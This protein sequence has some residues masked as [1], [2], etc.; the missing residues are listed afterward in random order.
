MI[1]NTDTDYKSLVLNGTKNKANL[2]FT[3]NEEYDSDFRKPVFTTILFINK[4]EYGKGQGVQK[5]G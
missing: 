4:E 2:I 5:R 3:Y 1:I